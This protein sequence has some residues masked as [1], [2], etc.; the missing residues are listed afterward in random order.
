[1]WAIIDAVCNKLNSS[2]DDLLKIHQLRRK[3]LVFMVIANTSK[4]IKTIKG[5]IDINYV[6]LLH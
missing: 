2:V 3:R 4:Y 5:F 1:M 6:L